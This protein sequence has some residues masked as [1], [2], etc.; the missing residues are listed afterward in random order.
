MKALLVLMLCTLLGCAGGGNQSCVTQTVLSVGPTSGTADHSAAAPGN[1]QQFVATTSAGTSTP[2]CAVPLVIAQVN[3]SWTTSD[4]LDT[5]ISSGPLPSNGL[6]TCIN[7]TS[8]PVTVT[9]TYT[10]G[11]TTLTRIATLT[12]K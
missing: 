3:A 12:C 8:Q 4:P 5:Q 2:G 10:A 9:A 1:Q 11:T 6:A 7:A